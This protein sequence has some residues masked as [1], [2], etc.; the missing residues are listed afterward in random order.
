MEMDSLRIEITDE[1][2]DGIFRVS[3][4]ILRSLLGKY[5]IWEVSMCETSTGLSVC[6]CVAWIAC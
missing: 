6:G 1:D 5:C 2:A 3:E 4:C